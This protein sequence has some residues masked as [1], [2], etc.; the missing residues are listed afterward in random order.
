MLDEGLASHGEMGFVVCI[1]CGRQQS[2][3]CEEGRYRPVGVQ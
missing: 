2:S 1:P 3:W